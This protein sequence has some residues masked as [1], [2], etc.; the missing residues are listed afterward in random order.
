MYTYMINSETETEEMHGKKQKLQREKHLSEFC[1]AKDFQMG[2]M[3]KFET[4]KKGYST[5]K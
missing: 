5:N 4:R 2:C 1:S 3:S